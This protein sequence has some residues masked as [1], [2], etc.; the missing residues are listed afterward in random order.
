MI[1]AADARFS[2]SGR[3]VGRY[4]RISDDIERE[5]KGVARQAA[6]E[7]LHIERAGG[8]VGPE[9]QEN[10]TSAYQKKRV[11][12]PNGTVVWRV[13][14]PVWQ[15][16]LE[17]LRTGVVDAA[18]VYDLDRLARDPRDLEDAIEVVEHYRRPILGVTGG[19]D[20]VTDNGRFTA[21]ILVAQANKASADTARRVARKHAEQQQAGVPMG[22]RR[23]FGWKADKR[24]LEPAEAD[25]LKRAA[26]RISAGTPVS[27]I[28][29]DWNERG[30][31]TSMGGRWVIGTVKHALRNPRVCG[32]RSRTV[33]D[34]DP[35]TGQTRK[36][37][38]LVLSAD[39]SPV[40]GQ[41]EPVLTVDEWQR[42]IA[43]MG[44][45]PR[46][47]GQRMARKYLLTGLARCGKCGRPLRG[48]S[49]ASRPHSR[50]EFIYA[51]HARSLG[52]CGGVG[53]HGPLTD[54][55]VTE[56]VLSKIDLELADATPAKSEW[57]GAAELEAIAGQIAELTEGWRAKQISSA[58]Y[59]AILPELEQRERELA[60]E[61]GRHLVDAAALHSRPADI[62]AGWPDYDLGQKRTIIERHLSAVVVHPA[63]RGT[64]FD[65]DLLEPVWRDD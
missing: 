30:I 53:R 59:F 54:Q 50:A 42:L 44:E 40:P 57:T 16:L 31:R 41:W 20:L 26:K 64:R 46:R 45:R 6:D 24:T 47:A 9:Y 49:Q 29:L 62:R 23:P 56:A 5:G 51:C 11:V 7:A 43:V 3:V 12:L 8:V 38:D 58:R 52:G 27:T 32:Y 10:D 55:Y 15:Q 35:A 28:V 25:E 19:F 18:I 14:R 63:R 13:I 33:S 61:R 60:S 34:F 39:G 17:D 22:G 37:T 4:T 1:D 21:R 36:Y 2:L 65:P 48:G